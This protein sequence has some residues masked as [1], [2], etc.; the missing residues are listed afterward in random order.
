MA[1]CEAHCLQC[2]PAPPCA[3]QQCLVEHA[4]RG[5][6]EA[7]ERLFSLLAPA[8]MQQAR[9]LCGADGM[10]QDVAQAALVLVLEHL[11]D[12]RRPNRVGAWVRRIVINAYRM[13]RR[14]RAAREQREEHGPGGASAPSRGEQLLDAR[15]ELWRILRAASLLPPLLAETF[16]LRVVEG[17]T[18]GQAAARLGVTPDVVRARLSRARRRLRAMEDGG[19]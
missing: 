10:A 18:T 11:P 17:L 19:R 16:R 8:V 4:Q 15:R 14:S 13:E 2:M 7:R 6:G 1:Y 5:D 12:L 9:R 3:G